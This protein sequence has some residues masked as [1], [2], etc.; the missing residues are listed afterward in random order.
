VAK[1]AAQAAPDRSEVRTIDGRYRLL[2]RLG[3][4]GMGEVWKAEDTA[5]ARDVAIKF[6]KKVE[7]A[8]EAERW[9][10]AEA[11]TV[12]RLNHKHLVA[13]LDRTRIPPLPGEGS[14][15]V[16]AL[17]FEYVSGRPLGLWADRPRPWRW[18]RGI[19]DQAL[20][21]LAY[22]HGRGV[23]HRDLKPSNILL[24]GDP[25][26]PWAHLLDFGIAA[27]AAP[28]HSR[29]DEPQSSLPRGSVPGTRAYMAPEQVLGDKGDIGP[30]TDLYAL[31]VVIAE[32]L[33]GK[34]PFPGERDED[35]WKYRKNN[36][37]A[38]PVQAL[39]DL[40]IPLRRFLL[41]LLA[42]DPAQRFGWAADARRALPAGNVAD[43]TTGA[44][45]LSPESTDVLLEA[46]RRPEDRNTDPDTHGTP[47][48]E[49]LSVG[50]S[51]TLELSEAEDQD[52][53]LPPSWVLDR[54]DPGAWEEGFRKLPEAPPAPVP[55]V[56]YSLLSMR[57]AP[58]HGRN[59][60]W[61]QAWAHLSRVTD[62]GRPVLLLVEGPQG[63]GKTRFARELAAV[64][65]EVG[66]CRSHHVRFRGDGSGAGA[67]RRLLH[68][69][70][71]V[72]ELAEEEREERVRRVLGEAGYP[73]E[74]DLVPRLLATLSPS[75]ARRG[76]GTEEAATAVELFR[77]LC[78]RR[79]LLIWMED[80]DRARD[81]ALVGLLQQVF[82]SEG[83]LPV[84]VVATAR[85]D[86]VPD[87]PEPPE[88]VLLR[89]QAETL[90]LKMP[91]LGDEAIGGVLA[92]TAGTAP[93]LGREVSRW[94]HGDPR[95][96]QQIARHLHESGR[97]KWTPA[98][99]ELRGDTPSTAGHLK[100]D[101]ILLARA[102]DSV[103]AAPDPA[104]TQTVL[105]LL[106]L[107]RERARQIDLLMAA[108]RVGV[109][110]RRVEAALAPLVMAQLVDVRDEGP[111]LAH[112]AL[113]ESI[114]EAM[115]LRRQM[116]FH[117]A[118]A[119]V[120]EGGGPGP[121]RADR[122]L[123]AAWNRASCGQQDQAARDELEA[124]QLLRARGE[125]A[126]A[127]RAAKAAADRVEGRHSLLQ[128]EEDA[129][130][131]VLAALLDHEVRDPPGTASELAA[132]LDMLQP[133]WAALP[134]CEQRC[135]AD[136]AHADALRRAGRPRDAGDSL[137]RGL[138]G[139][140]ATG[141]AVWECRALLLLAD[142][143]RLQ[144]ALDDA[145]RNADKA[146]Q[147]AVGLD[148]ESLMLAVL[149]ARLPLAVASKD[150]DQ[151]RLL[152]DKLR[153]LLRV[154]ASWQDLQ[155]LWW[156]RGEVE[157]VGA[158]D[159]AARQAY[160]TA[161]VLGRKRGL[162][163]APVL[164]SMAVMQLRAGELDGAKGS[165]DEAGAAQMTGSPHSHELRAARSLLLAELSLRR[166]AAAEAAAALQDAEI[167]QA[168]SPLA[169][170]VL[171]ESLARS[172]GAAKEGPGADPGLLL[173]V[174]ALGEAMAARLRANAG[175]RQAGEKAGGKGAGAAGRGPSRKA[176]S[177]GAREG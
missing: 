114:H 58:L 118:W 64:A 123:E 161:L 167:L 120:L 56:S 160:Q 122:L 153:T 81:R 2:K 137:Q 65:E 10:L 146:W 45:E 9:L 94:S 67:L 125:L 83:E 140:K 12:A 66:V 141:S 88:W 97:L 30:W 70:L 126:A 164:L 8:E 168:Q 16:P 78:R 29:D 143:Q 173:R 113:A 108:A 7:H 69:V 133:L 121:G 117:R 6:P 101:A 142:M 159:A 27:W 106:S 84:A 54:P 124:A 51:I 80:I 44:Q 37:F 147:H 119:T 98:G 176:A 162:A 104:A 40:G 129:D 61:K 175:A 68:R 76:S 21:A 150:V 32:L 103:R 72:A 172:R 19:A 55:A 131:Q 3:Q 82:N 154:R 100:L 171:L 53:A 127:W 170:P 116:D 158:N 99:W 177:A 62:E 115:D 96:A 35:I 13:L 166:G 152:L 85:D 22:A 79:P 155:N 23:V 136:L 135:R 91:A 28:G 39:A 102:R 47:A 109:E 144:G 89:A 92:Y 59:G 38:P 87:D 95:A 112:L 73:A 75:Q 4:G 145:R 165:L 169:D 86:R 111:R 93:H 49:I 50:G 11:Q 57:D 46:V 77:V 174:E 14:E 48:E 17:V 163:N 90:V 139:A 26:K 15:G 149:G 20:S 128:P 71:R 18:V 36:R 42:P 107:L 132:A 151:A 105:D 134:P 25:L 60:E 138:E 74:A 110:S 63:R 5:L 52:V 31:G 157:R 1:A 24:S 130:L 148:D 34:L 41:R 33:L 156:L 43:L